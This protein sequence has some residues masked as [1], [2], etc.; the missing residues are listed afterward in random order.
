MEHIDSRRSGYEQRLQAM[1]RDAQHKAQ[2]KFDGEVK[3]STE[4]KRKTARC[5]TIT[6]WHLCKHRLQDYFSASYPHCWMKV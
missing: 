5:Q 3:S 2:L 4:V 6:Y 1:Q